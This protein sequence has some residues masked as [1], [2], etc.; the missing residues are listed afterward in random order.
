MKVIVG[1]GNPGREYAGT[2]HNVG[3]MV[4]DY[5]ADRWGVSRF[6]ARFRGLLAEA[7]LG[8]EKILLFK[9]QTFMNLSGQAVFDLVSFYKL[10][11]ADLLVVFDDLDL[12]TGRLRGRGRGGS[13][14]HRGVESIIYLLG[15]E[16]FPRLKIGIGRPPDQRPAA[17]HV[18]TTF[19]PEEAFAMA[20]V[21]QRVADAVELW[22]KVGITEVMN[23]FNASEKPKQSTGGDGDGGTE[24]NGQS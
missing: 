3:F 21:I 10:K 16:D 22:V 20:G 15:S 23:R 5:L 18:L 17:A 1:L 4:V 8:T 12:S 13:G 2:R 19:R 7:W 11:P 24:G 9:P 6:Q 14:G